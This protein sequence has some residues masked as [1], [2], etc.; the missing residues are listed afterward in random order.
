MNCQ[1]WIQRNEKFR[2]SDFGTAIMAIAEDW[3]G[4]EAPVAQFLWELINI[5]GRHPSAISGQARS[6]GFDCMVKYSCASHDDI[7]KSEIQNA[8]HICIFINHR[9]STMNYEQ[10]TSN[11]NS[12]PA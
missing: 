11:N 3:N 1:D 7:P 9:Q 4:L 8:L 12:C 2:M 6:A 5:R 10:S